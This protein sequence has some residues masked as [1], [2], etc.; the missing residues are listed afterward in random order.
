MHISSHTDYSLRLLIYLAVCTEENRQGTVQDASARYHVSVN[1]LAKVA[2]TLVQLGYIN[3]YRGRGG[4]ISLAV[5]PEQ[6]RLGK[7]VRETENLQLLECFGS[8]P[9]CPIE[10]DCRLKH[11][12]SRAQRAF[13]AVLDEHVLSDLVS[14]KR[15]LMSLLQ[16]S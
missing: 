3:S 9:E 16:F 7:I 6:I 14:N 2:Q 5:P 13:L 4:G 1:H 11:I 10:P 15:V 8:H 12:F